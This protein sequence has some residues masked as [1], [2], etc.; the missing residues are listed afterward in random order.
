M[1]SCK[2]NSV[3]YYQIFKGKKTSK[4]QL[5]LE[6]ILSTSPGILLC[7][8]GERRKKTTGKLRNQ[9]WA[10]IICNRSTGLNSATEKPISHYFIFKINL[11]PHSTT[12]AI[13]F[14]LENRHTGVFKHAWT[15]VSLGSRLCRR[16]AGRTP[17]AN[18]RARLQLFLHLQAILQGVSRHKREKEMYARSK[19]QRNFFKQR[20]EIQ[21]F[22]TYE[23]SLWHV[24]FQLLHAL[25]KYCSIHHSHSTFLPKQTGAHSWSSELSIYL[26]TLSTK[27]KKKNKKK[28]T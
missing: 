7:P 1:L 9:I 15:T 22:R 25:L 27:F 6:A 14:S 11:L 13:P 8:K 12:L 23:A 19:C 17:K 26:F 3:S 4:A 5:T 2:A 24:P 20:E 18:W 10:T 21:Y 28:Q 16:L